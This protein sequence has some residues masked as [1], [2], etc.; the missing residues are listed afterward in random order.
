LTIDKINNHKNIIHINPKNLYILESWQTTAIC[1][2]FLGVS[3]WYVSYHNRNDTQCREKCRDDGLWP[4]HFMLSD[5]SKLNVT[6]ATCTYR[7][8]HTQ[9]S[10][11]ANY[12]T[13]QQGLGSIQL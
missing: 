13:L 3:E 6:A 1:T 11:N 7:R 8:Q 12:I 9:S 5:V 10:L 4:S 2:A